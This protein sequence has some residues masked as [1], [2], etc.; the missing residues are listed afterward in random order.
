MFNKKIISFFTM[1]IFLTIAFISQ[2]NASIKVEVRSS[3]NGFF[4]KYSVPAMGKGRV[5]LQNPGD[6]ETVKIRVM[7]VKLADVELTLNEITSDPDLVSL[8]YVVTSK[9]MPETEAMEG[10]FSVPFGDFGAEINFNGKKFVSTGDSAVDI[11]LLLTKDKTEYA[12]NIN[13]AI[14]LFGLE[15]N[16]DQDLAGTATPADNIIQEQILNPIDDSVL[17]DINIEVDYSSN[18]YTVLNYEI[19][20]N[21]PSVGPQEDNTGDEPGIPFQGKIT[22]PNGSYHVWADMDF[23]S[24]VPEIE[25][26]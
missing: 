3:E 25:M 6:T 13:F 22:L 18:L 11:S 1:A 5:N 4:L 20:P 2:A 16:F 19:V 15:L 9:N 8:H 23:E 17:L 10:D 24:F 12:A 7:M 14:A 21:M 26:P